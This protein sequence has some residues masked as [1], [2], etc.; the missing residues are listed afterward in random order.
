MIETESHFQE[1]R[2]RRPQSGRLPILLPAMTRCECMAM[3]FEELSRR[4]SA[5][6][7]TLAQAVE[8]TGC[9]GMCSACL[10]DLRRYLAVENETAA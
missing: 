9:G 10:P 4:M 6:R 3:S 1:E 8:R 7:W 2:G 5:E